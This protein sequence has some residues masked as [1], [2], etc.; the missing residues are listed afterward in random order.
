MY[1][2]VCKAVT[3]RQIATAATKDGVTRMRELR[4]QLGVTTQCNRCA[5][6]AYQCLRSALAEQ[7]Q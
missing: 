1:V 2:C 3:E 6:H 4:Q 7:A 5:A